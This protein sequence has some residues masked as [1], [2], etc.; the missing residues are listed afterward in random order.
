MCGCVSKLQVGQGVKAMERIMG[1]WLTDVRLLA[2]A[3]RV[4]ESFVP[5]SHP[6]GNQREK[7]EFN[8]RLSAMVRAEVT[9]PSFSFAR[10]VCTALSQ[11][12]SS[13]ESGVS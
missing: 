11:V 1:D 2:K 5:A 9:C 3:G 8:K 12:A 7:L 6:A 4:Q 10:Y 13:Q